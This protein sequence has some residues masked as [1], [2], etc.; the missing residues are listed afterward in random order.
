MKIATILGA[1][2]QFVKAAMLSMEWAKHPA[3]QEC[4]I[5]TGQHFD[6][7]MSR[8][9]FEEMQIPKPKYNLG[10]NG[11]SHAAMTGQM[12]IEI[13]KVLLLEK[14]DWVV[15]FGDT[16]STLAGALVAKKMGLKIAHIEA[17]LRSFNTEMPEE[18]NRVL[19][20][21]ISDIL[22]CPTEL[23]LKNLEKEGFSDLPSRVL[24]SGDIMYD[25]ILHFKNLALETSTILSKLDLEKG[26]YILATIHREGNTAKWEN[27]KEILEA[28][29]EINKSQKIVL[30]AHP[31]TKKLM[32][33]NDWTSSLKLIEPLGY[34]NML[35]IM[36]SS[37]FIIS[38]SGGLQK[39]AYW[40]KKSCLIIREETE[41]LELVDNGNN[42]LAGIKRD[43]IVN[44]YSKISKQAAGF[45]IP[46][47]GRGETAKIVVC[48][49]IDSSSIK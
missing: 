2:P 10:I 24:L 26:S 39:E 6:E 11:L 17:G 22:C 14:P 46:F 29:E 20:D 35:T 18:I 23:S 44:G 37:A 30:V 32:T 16:N 8:V 45:E 40:L 15:V 13:E 49:I 7:N 31:R 38:D 21:R 41:W 48:E 36:D 47:Y 19:V 33:D 3:I 27:L 1:R 25:A 9:F 4:I 43:T 28:F 42:I 34:F 12:M 5:H